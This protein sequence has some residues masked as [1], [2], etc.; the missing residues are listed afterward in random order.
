MSV[1][2]NAAPNLAKLLPLGVRFIERDWLS[3]NQVLMFDADGATL[4]DSGYR[5]HAALTEAL[6]Q[7]Q[8]DAAGHCT[9]LRV[10]NTHMHSD[11]CGG[12]AHLSRVYGCKIRIPLADAEVVARWDDAS[13][14]H[15]RMGQTIERFS[16]DEF[17]QPGDQ[18]QLGGALW[19]VLAAPGHDQH[20]LMFYCPSHGVLI[21]AD[22]FWEN[23]FGINFP[24]LAGDAS[25]FD[26]QRAVLDLIAQLPISVVIPGHGPMFSDVG[27]ALTRAYQRLSA[28]QAD[29]VR[30]ARYAIKALIKFQ[31]L[32]RERVEE[33]EFLASLGR[34]EILQRC[35]ALTKRPAP[36]AFIEAIDALVAQSALKR[37]GGQ[38][39]NC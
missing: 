28:Q 18:W 19:Q 33:Q 13:M 3:S 31:M 38:V 23:G 7:N 16:A 32:D 4:I 26:A 35:A 39:L 8:L 1:P 21:S 15:T 11:H 37:A 25:G 2:K 9:L 36:L 29:P 14:E 10:I 34:T 12:N 22:A 6:V 27:S 5:K 30:H 20:S 24:A 17:S